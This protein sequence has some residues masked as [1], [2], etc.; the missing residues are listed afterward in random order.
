MWAF[1]NGDIH[2]AVAIPSAKVVELSKDVHLREVKGPLIWVVSQLL[3]GAL[4]ALL[5]LLVQPHTVGQLLQH[6]STVL[7][8]H[9]VV[10]TVC[11]VCPARGD[12]LVGHLHK[13]GCHPL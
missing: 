13:Q 12:H 2:K 7:V 8:P 5:V 6:H 9:L 11:D 1:S 3:F 10:P 4:E